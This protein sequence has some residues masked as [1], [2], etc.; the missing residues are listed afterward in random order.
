MPLPQTLIEV[1]LSGAL[2]VL[3]EFSQ[4]LKSATVAIQATHTTLTL[5]PADVQLRRWIFCSGSMQWS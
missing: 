1:L 3:R 2:P 4:K 5:G